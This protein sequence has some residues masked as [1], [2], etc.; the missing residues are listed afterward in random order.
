MKKALI[1]VDMQN[2]FMPG[3]PLAVREGD[4]I[5][6]IINR[7]VLQS[8]DLIAATQDWHPK[9]H[10]SF[11]KNQEKT[12]GEVIKWHGIDQ[13]LWPMHCIQNTPGAEFV[14]GLDVSSVDYI[15]H[16]GTDS[17]IDSYSTFFD[18]HRLKSTGLE[19]ILREKKIDEV[20]FV[21]LAT[22][23]CVKHSVLDALKLGFKKV[24]VIIDACRGVNMFP[25]DTQKAI[26]EMTELGAI[27]IKSDE[28]R[29]GGI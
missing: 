2:D 24:Y 18:N 3:G 20:Y 14:A 21:G 12:P 4:R 8:F 23:Y 29:G 27:M 26:N 10:A 13:V 6:P 25:D 11:A 17:G 7:L 9:D 19:K 16:K 5:V 15:V 28:I 1:I 22:D